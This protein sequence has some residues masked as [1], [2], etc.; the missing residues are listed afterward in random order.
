MLDGMSK[1]IEICKSKLRKINSAEAELM[2][3]I[4][5]LFRRTITDLEDVSMVPSIGYRVDA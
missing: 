1:E 3:N 4:E 2:Q 5:K